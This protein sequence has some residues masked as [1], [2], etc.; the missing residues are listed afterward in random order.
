MNQIRVLV[1]TSFTYV[2]GSKVSYKQCGDGFYLNP[3]LPEELQELKFVLESSYLKKGLIH[4]E[5]Q[6]IYDYK[7]K[8]GYFLESISEPTQVEEVKE[9]ETVIEAVNTFIAEE[10]IEE[11]ED[12]WVSKEELQQ[13]EQETTLTKEERSSELSAL[14]ASE[15]RELAK[16]LDSDYVNKVKAIESILA[17]EYPE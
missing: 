14:S 17:I 8:T 10:P 7:T 2:Y 12:F 11:V 4:V 16:T 13:V 5:D 15:I 9:P 3:S 1:L 6:V